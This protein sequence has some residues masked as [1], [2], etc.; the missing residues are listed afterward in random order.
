MRYQTKPYHWFL[1]ILAYMSPI[2][3]TAAMYAAWTV[4]ISW[5]VLKNLYGCV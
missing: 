2:A 3:G 5:K 1:A 4:A